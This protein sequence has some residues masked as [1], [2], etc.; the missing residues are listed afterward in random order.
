MAGRLA[1][2]PV[3]VVCAVF[4]GG[5]TWKNVSASEKT[6]M[7]NEERQFL[8]LFLAAPPKR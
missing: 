1:D 2:Q 8:R 7:A 3:T 5:H 4:P 6:L